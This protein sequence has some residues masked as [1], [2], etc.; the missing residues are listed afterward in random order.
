MAHRIIDKFKRLFSG[1]A[2]V[3]VEN[4]EDL[5]RDFKERY[6]Y[7]KQLLTANT[8]SLEGFAEIERLLKEPSH[9]GMSAVRANVT[10]VLVS[11][12]RMVRKMNLL[13]PGKYSK[14]KDSYSLI[15]QE[16]DAV[17]NRAPGERD[18][19]FV[20][21]M[22][23]I[24]SSM[25]DSVGQKMANLGELKNSLNL[26]VPDG[27]VM[28]A[29]A[30]DFFFRENGL[31]TEINRKFKAQPFTNIEEM[32]TL[33]L[34]IQD[35]IRNAQVPD[36]L[37][38]SITTA[39]KKI[40]DRNGADVCFAL[41]SSALGEDTLDASFA[42]QYKTILNIRAQD[43]I[44]TYKE[45]LAGKYSVTAIQY[46]LNRGFKDEDVDMCVGCSAMVDATS[47]GVIYTRHPFDVRDDSIYIQS[48]WGLPKAVVDGSVNC[49]LFVVSRGDTPQVRQKNVQ[50]KEK[51]FMC[52][53][54]EGV[55]RFDFIDDMQM[56]PSLTENLILEITRFAQRIE[57]HYGTP[58]D[59]EWAVV[60]QDDVDEQ[61]YLLQTRPLKLL[62][63]K[64]DQKTFPDRHKETGLISDSGITASPGA[65]TG[66]GYVASSEADLTGFPEDA[67]LI[68]ERALPRWAPLLGRA[69]ALITEK[70]SFASHLANVAREFGVPAI[71]GVQGA[72]ALL[73][74]QDQI[75]IDADNCRIYQGRVD[76][77]L[78]VQE[79]KKN[80]MAGSPVHR[81]LQEIAQHII[82]LNLLDPD[83]PDFKPQ[84]C[85]TL[86]DITRFIHEKSVAEMFNYGKNFGFDEVA[87]KQLYDK[88]PMQ[89]WVM[90]LDDGFKNNVKGKY[91]NLS[92]ISSIP[93]LAVWEGIVA[94]P[95]DG[96]PPVDRKG[97]MSVMFEATK[98]T[99]LNT[100]VK[101]RYSNRN[102]FMISEQ[103]CC[104]NS[105]LGFHFITLEAYVGTR[106]SENYVSFRFQGGAAN[107]TRRLKRVQLIADFLSGYGFK[108]TIKEDHLNARLKGYDADYM[109]ERLKIIGYMTIHTRQLDMVATNNAMVKSYYNK[110]KSDIE[111]VFNINM[112][113][114][115]NSMET[116]ESLG[117]G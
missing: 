34:E 8:T 35:L 102:Y 72:C 59:I 61:I 81:T 33:C 30:C 29:E 92:E 91:V 36:T 73:G 89:W 105:R 83:A 96:P 104:L 11:I 23:D 94:V 6:F 86:H 22:S 13:A 14:L 108:V 60:V 56:E 27:F 67:V 84:N 74:S 80:L 15:S 95:W 98:N 66:K 93:M 68:V 10:A 53:A 5:R 101:S 107:Q 82:P 32:H 100:G 109:T 25:S 54:D 111:S 19:R 113:A 97:L 75:T 116:S 90:N 28:T 70:G 71:F 88:V 76:S 115:K 63:A 69:A 41:R 106:A 44:H 18:K 55:C 20:I 79:T 26:K 112:Q 3:P 117:D 39:V 65:A 51:K 24:D 9:F 62:R 4:S 58:Q 49:D 2:A 114:E 45:I 110:F 37:A 103:Y 85:R 31:Q 17:L 1:P 57:D 7:F 52:Y 99:A 21:P 42:G 64:K 12:Y 87:S 48:T 47:G 16:I 78:E 77:I 38:H 50:K 43:V 46:R 40:Q